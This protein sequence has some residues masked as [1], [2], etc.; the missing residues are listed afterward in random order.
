LSKIYLFIQVGLIS[1]IHLQVGN[2]FCEGI[3]LPNRLSYG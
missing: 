1:I 2:I 3:K